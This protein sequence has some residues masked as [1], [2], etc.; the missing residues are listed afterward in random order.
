MSQSDLLFVD[1]TLLFDCHS[2]PDLQ[3]QNYRKAINSPMNT[4]TT[5]KYLQITNV[6]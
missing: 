3:K 4:N 1:S 5:N 6:P 2:P